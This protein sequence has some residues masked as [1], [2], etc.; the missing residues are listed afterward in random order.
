M[1]QTPLQGILFDFDGL[2]LDTETPIFQAWEEKFK[3]YGKTLLLEE[4]AEI[5]GKSIDHLGPIEG[6][7]N[8]FPDENKKKE[9]QE[10]V[11]QKESELVFKKKP[12]PGVV[13]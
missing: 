13:N 4:W 7:L 8:G 1:L 12:L 9:I 10:E 5:L 6:F 2:I 3:E 11:R